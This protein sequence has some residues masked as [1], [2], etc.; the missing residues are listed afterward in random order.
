MYSPPYL[1]KDTFGGMAASCYEISSVPY[2][3]SSL[4]CVC[5]SC[6][7]CLTLCDPMDMEVHGIIQARILECGMPFPSSKS[8]FKAVQKEVIA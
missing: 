4:V 6:S 2:C 5:V 1:S 7:G 8:S 3:K